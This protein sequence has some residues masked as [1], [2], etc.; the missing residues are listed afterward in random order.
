M[1][2]YEIYYG[3]FYVCEDCNFIFSGLGG[4]ANYE[5]E[6][7]CPSCDGDFDYLPVNGIEEYVTALKKELKYI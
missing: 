3:E 5:M 7:G 6:G 4:Q 2:K 1:N